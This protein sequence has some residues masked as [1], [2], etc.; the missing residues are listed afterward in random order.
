MEKLRNA[1]LIK[2][3]VKFNKIVGEEG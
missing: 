3:D 1:A 2:T